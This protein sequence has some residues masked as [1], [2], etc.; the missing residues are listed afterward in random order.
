MKKEGPSVTFPPVRG[1]SNSV[2]LH[3]WSVT[4]WSSFCGFDIKRCRLPA[5]CSVI[6]IILPLTVKGESPA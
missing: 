5:E 6:P 4:I 1:G 3:F 2:T